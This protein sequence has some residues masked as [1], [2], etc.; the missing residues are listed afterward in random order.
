MT[1]AGLKGKLLVASPT[2]RDPNFYRS[3][4]LVLEHTGEGALGLVL[5]RP[6]ET[7]VAEPLPGWGQLSA[8]PH[9]VFVGGPVQPNAAICLARLGS[10]PAGEGIGW[11]PLG[12]GLGTLDLDRDPDE[13]APHVESVRI[14]VGYAGWAP[15]QVEGEMGERAWLVVDAEPDDPMTSDPLRL[16]KTVLRRQGGERAVLA[17]YPDNPSLN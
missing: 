15:G 7:A 12:A 3:V 11:N 13:V 5:N 14:F 4:I 2:L 9:V 16:W 1:G 6:S 17:G 8:D 10:E